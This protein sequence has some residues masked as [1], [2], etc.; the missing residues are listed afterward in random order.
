MDTGT[1]LRLA[2]EQIMGQIGHTFDVFTLARPTNI[3][4]AL[5]LVKILSKLS[6]LVGNLIEFS[7]V[8]LLNQRGEFRGLGR[9]ARQDPDFPDTVFVGKVDPQPGLE[10]KAWFPL[11]TEIT[12]RFKDSQDRFR[13]KNVNVALLAWL[14]ENL[15]FGR[16]H[17]L[18]ACVV[19]GESVASARDSHYHDPPNYLVVEPEDTT[20]RTRNLQQ[21]NTNGYRWQGTA[22]QLREAERVVRSWGA[23][24]K[25]YRPDRKYRAQVRALISRFPY[26]LDTNFAKMDRIEHQE[27]EDFKRRMLETEL[28]G[29]KLAAW[30][31]IFGTDD[32]A[33]IR[34]ALS[35]GLGIEHSVK[36]V[37]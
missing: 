28:F 7:A 3:E 35:S 9:W 14:P 11:A 36:E 31:A 6:P 24:G 26:R 17:L 33:R 12:A 25:R 32:Q 27:I 10:I 34:E 2:T 16:P 8:E 1:V 21:T 30:S 13:Q 4:W 20:A 19:S 22:R 29:K 18:G 5:D 37:A 23:G 15:I